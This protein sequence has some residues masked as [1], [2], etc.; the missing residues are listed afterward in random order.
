LFLAAA[1]RT[2][3]FAERS[4]SSSRSAARYDVCGSLEREVVANRVGRWSAALSRPK[5]GKSSSH[6]DAR[7]TGKNRTR[8]NLGANSGRD[9]LGIG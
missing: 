5:V 4:I 9:G 1:S 3:G 2:N 6:D 7:M 8:R